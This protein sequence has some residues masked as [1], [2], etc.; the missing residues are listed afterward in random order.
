MKR[1]H[2][3]ATITGE[4]MGVLAAVSALLPRLNSSIRVMPLDS[5][6]S[7]ANVRPRRNDA[8]PH[9]WESEKRLKTKNRRNSGNKRGETIMA[10][11]ELEVTTNTYIFAGIGA[12]IIGALASFAL[13]GLQNTIAAAIVGGLAGG[14]LGL[15]F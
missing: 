3:I 9:L 8:P 15:F 14:C 5:F 7:Y 2:M 13:G 12:V 4:N 1:P 10:S 6:P 11:K